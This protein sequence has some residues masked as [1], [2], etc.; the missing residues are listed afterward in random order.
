MKEIVSWTSI[1]EEFIK[2]FIEKKGRLIASN[3]G[4]KTATTGGQV[5][6]INNNDSKSSDE[7][8]NKKSLSYDF[9]K[10]ATD[11]SKIKHIYQK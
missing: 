10:I 1:D 7:G 9:K 5:N 6:N 11:I 2:E 4:T 3:L 8:E